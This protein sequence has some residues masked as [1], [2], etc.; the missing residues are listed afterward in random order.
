[1]SQS[2]SE[3]GEEAPS[4][5]AGWSAISRLIR[6][7]WSWSGHERNVALLNVSTRTAGGEAI[8]RFADISGLTGLD[9]LDDGRALARIDWD[10]DGDLD[11]VSTA[12]TAPRVRVLRNDLAPGAGW[13]AV[14]LMG[15]APNTDAIGAR[16]EVE[17]EGGLR[18]MLV[19][20]RRAGEGFLAQSSAWLHFGLG[21]GVV[22][23][24]RVHWPGGETE[25]F[26]PVRANRA[27]SLVQGSGEA[28]PWAS[29]SVPDLVESPVR[30]PD[31]PALSRLVTAVPIPV[32]T[33]EAR[34][35]GRSA[36][37]FGVGPG[38]ARGTGRPTLVMLFSRNCQPC[39]GELARFAE[40]RE[41]L[42]AAG[43][44]VLALSVDPESDYEAVAAFVQRTGSPGTVAFATR[45]T[46]EVLD[47]LAGTLRDDYRTLA[48]PSS[49]LVDSSGLLQVVYQ[50]RLEPGQ[51][52]A[53]MQLERITADQRPLAAVPFAGRL[54]RPHDPPSLAWLT[55]AFERRGLE[56][57][58]AEVSLGSIEV[59]NVDE[60]ELQVGFGK[61][62]LGQERFADAA[63]HFQRGVELDPLSLDAWKGLGYCRH[64]L[65]K[66]E[67]AR[68][69]YV[70]ARALAPTDEL[71][72]VNLALV[73]VELGD[74]EAARA[75][76]ADLIL[77]GS[78]YAEVVE[79][80]LAR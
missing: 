31:R 16:V 8:C 66:L 14:R 27:V 60:A 29:P 3:F 39:A 11:L 33:L 51:V 61:A 80:A 76:L 62:R 58:A 57:A 6:Q 17:L 19:E 40:A 20:T 46:L 36:N 43:L 45:H 23:D 26:G 74:R 10:Q 70:R 34:A 55:A 73:L 21:K 77:R 18:P 68:D 13:L 72:Q 28:R 35:G 42:A 9:L 12:R 30:A 75:E 78:E 67:L 47:A 63:E 79:R 4:Y 71:N 50:G 54:V 64:R 1:M 5:H 69:A 38:G 25:S 44:E 32:P 41:Q 7:G 59:R 53:D 52:L 22:T 49:F 15:A 65:G 24:L 56:R 37:F 2:P 48:L